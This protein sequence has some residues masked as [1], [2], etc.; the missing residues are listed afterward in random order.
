MSE[1]VSF[2]SEF[3]HVSEKIKAPSEKNY[4]QPIHR[5]NTLKY[6]HIAVRNKN[7]EKLKDKQPNMASR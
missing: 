7:K 4:S 1:I 6:Q 3:P 5:I 2:F